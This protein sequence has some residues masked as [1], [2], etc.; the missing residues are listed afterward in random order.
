MSRGKLISLILIFAALV[1]RNAAA[2]AENKLAVPAPRTKVS[3]KTKKK[4][5]LSSFEAGAG[6]QMW[7]EKMTISNA[8]SK[9][10][11]VANYAGLS[12]ILEEN[13]MRNHWQ[14]GVAASYATGKASSGGFDTLTYTDGVDRTWSAEQ[15]TLFG[16]Y[17]LNT[18]FMAG[19]GLFGRS[20][21]SDWRSSDPNLTIRHAA[22]FDVAGQ[23]MLRW[24]VSQRFSF[25]QS[26]IPL[27]F[28]GSTMWQWTAQIVL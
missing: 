11:G 14:Y 20:L 3:A 18:T 28:N 12:L 10:T 1:S 8:T 22:N 21:Q 5:F 15:L 25:T 6:Y 24:S 7:N 19:L 16:H 26:F 4:A 17:R 2:D 9:S 27:D 23:L 13:W